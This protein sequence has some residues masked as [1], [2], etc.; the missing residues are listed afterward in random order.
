MPEQWPVE[1]K[2]RNG[3]WTVLFGGREEARCQDKQAAFEIGR[4]IAER[5][6][7]EFACDDLSCPKS[8][9]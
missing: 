6:H 3:V 4:D 8:V 5:T 7:S 1:V 9:R 2:H